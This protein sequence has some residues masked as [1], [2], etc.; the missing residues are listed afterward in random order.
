[1]CDKCN[2]KIGLSVLGNL[3]MALAMAAVGPLPFLPYSASVSGIFA[4]AALEGVAYG[5]NMVS[6]FARAA[7]AAIDLGYEYNLNTFLVI[8]GKKSIQ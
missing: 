8:S 1:L 6:S 4:A 2:L 3:A 5:L 7:A